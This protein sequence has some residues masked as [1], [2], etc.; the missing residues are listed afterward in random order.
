M[1]LANE[2]LFASIRGRTQ[3]VLEIIMSILDNIF[4]FDS[5]I[6]TIEAIATY[7]F[8]GEYIREG[9]KKTRE[10]EGVQFHSDLLLSEDPIDKY[11]AYK[12]LTE[13]PCKFDADNSL[14]T[15]SLMREIYSKLWGA[16]AEYSNFVTI[17]D[18]FDEDEKKV[19]FGGDVYNS[20]QTS[21]GLP[22]KECIKM[23]VNAPKKLRHL[24]CNMQEIMKVSHVLGN[25]GL[26]PAYYN[27]YRGKNGTIKDYLDR[28]LLELRENGFN[29]LDILIEKNRS[30]EK[31]RDLEAFTHKKKSLYRDFETSDYIKYIN[32]MFLWDMHTEGNEIRDI[33]SNVQIWSEIVPKII[34]RRSLFMA[35]M[36]FFSHRKEEIYSEML[37]KIAH[38][39][40]VLDYEMTF[41]L[42]ESVEGLTVYDVKILEEVKSKIQMVLCRNGE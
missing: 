4:Y 28:S 9:Y 6:E 3:Y 18:C 14:G 7:D 30:A 12:V 35:M 36:L 17:K 37:V 29:Y 39:D 5:P 8:R 24:L 31:K 10:A 26:V 27:S 21:I 1:V 11:V 16:T 38:A 40:R 41:G 25:F 34:I 13:N 15:C 22:K 20:L 33:S 42:F 23:Y 32:M 2:L 19:L